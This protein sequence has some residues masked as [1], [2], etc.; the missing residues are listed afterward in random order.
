MKQAECRFK[1]GS[2]QSSLMAERSLPTRCGLLDHGKRNE[3]PINKAAGFRGLHL[4]V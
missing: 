3:L 1:A 2:S 4:P